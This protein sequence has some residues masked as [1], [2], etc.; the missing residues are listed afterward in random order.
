MTLT[1][2]ASANNSTP[3]GNYANDISLIATGTF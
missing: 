3:A 1:F 2:G